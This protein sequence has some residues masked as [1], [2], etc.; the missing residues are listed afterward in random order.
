MEKNTLRFEWND[1]SEIGHY[2]CILLDGDNKIDE[3]TFWDYTCKYHQKSDKKNRFHRP[4]AFKVHWCNG[5]SMSEGFDPDPEYNKK[6]GYQGVATHSVD[7]VKRWCE[8]WLADG[9]IEAYNNMLKELDTA[10]RRA[11]WFTEHGYG[12]DQI[13]ASAPESQR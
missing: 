10:R 12:K 2:E 11:V 4:Y 6:Y 5:W 7:D 1:S 3:I 9:Y 13:V 8:N